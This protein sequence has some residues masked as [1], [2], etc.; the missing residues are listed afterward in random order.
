VG[1]FFSEGTHSLQISA[2]NM[3]KGKVKTFKAGAGNT[4]VEVDLKG[5]DETVSMISRASSERLELKPD[6]EIYAVI[7]ASSVMIGIDQQRQSA[8][9][10]RGA[11]KCAPCFFEYLLK[12]RFFRLYSGK[13][14]CFSEPAHLKVS[15][16]QG[17]RTSGCSRKRLRLPF[18]KEEQL[19]WIEYSSSTLF[20]CVVPSW[21][22]TG[23]TGSDGPFVC[24]RR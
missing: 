13:A 4:E 9:S 16:T 11:D 1:I 14:D 6:K 5:G 2:R 22:S 17:S 24:D 21:L 7:K 8:G 19:C 18:G 12:Y 15:N 23:G 10:S 20:L 3:L